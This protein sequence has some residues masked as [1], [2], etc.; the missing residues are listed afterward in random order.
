MAN[1]P[2]K[3]AVKRKSV[4]YSKYGYFFIAPFFI[5][6]LIFQLY[7]L[8]NTFYWSFFSYVKR[9]LNITMNF[10][11][12]Q[13]YLN[14]LGLAE[15]EKAYFF[16]YLKNTVIMWLCGFIPQI[17]LSL[18]LA[19][20]LTNTR[21]K[22]RGA[23]TIKVM[24]YMPNIIA[25]SSISVLFGAL[26]SQ[27]G[28]ITV[29]LKKLGVIA[30]NFDFMQSVPGTRGLISFIL[31]WMWYGNTTLLLISGMMGISPALYEAAEIDGATGRQ[32]FFQI[33]LPLLKPIMLY[34]L[35][36]SAIGGFQMYDIP[37]L[38]NCTKTGYQGLPGDTTTTVTMYIMRLYSSDIGK[39]AAVCVMLFIVTL[40][41]SLL[42][43]STMN[44]KDEKRLKKERKA[45][46]KAAR[47]EAQKE[48][49]K[50]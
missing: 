44:D 9:N 48:A 46:A 47:K 22:V 24:T 36:T 17:L 23:G 21:V 42:F 11:G 5:I 28:P 25:A 10:C 50:V 30:S 18:L 14:V 43:F 27:Y 12:L 13:N 37:A 38:F 41:V 15:G 31:F 45:A 8:L 19:A 20:W 33:T 1:K 40:I 16:I 7:P 32:S 29:T 49:A 34:V 26:F 3:P 2:S 4:S 6:Y 35:V 39:A